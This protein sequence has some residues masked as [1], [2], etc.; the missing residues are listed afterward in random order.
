[1]RFGASFSDE[2]VA[3]ADGKGEI[4][5]GAAVQVSELAASAPEFHAAESVRRNRHVG[6]ACDRARD[7]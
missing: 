7:A 2:L 3:D 4:G 6:P 1:M 5:E